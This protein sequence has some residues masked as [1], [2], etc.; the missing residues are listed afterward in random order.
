MAKIGVSFQICPT[1]KEIPDDQCGWDHLLEGRIR[2][3]QIIPAQWRCP[4][5]TI[6]C[7]FL[8]TH[9]TAT[10]IHEVLLENPVLGVPGWAVKRERE[11]Q[12]QSLVSSTNF[13]SFTGCFFPIQFVTFPRFLPYPGNTMFGPSFYQFTP[14]RLTRTGQ[15]GLRPVPNPRQTFL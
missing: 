14:H 9:T 1:L 5:Q 12:L 3:A 11:T 8:C 6:S 15:H 7:M 4:I 10:Q 13:F 2:K